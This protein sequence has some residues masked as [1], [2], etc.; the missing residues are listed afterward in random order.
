MQDSEKRFLAAKRRLFDKVFE[1]KLNPEQ[2]RAVFTVKGPVLVLAG[3]GSGKTT[4]LVN[5]IAYII[6]YG[7]AYFSHEVPEGVTED[8][9]LAL[10]EAYSLPAEDIEEILPQFITEPTPPWAVLAITFT[11]KA[12]N[13]IKD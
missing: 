7:N 10:E 3:A 9:V 5:R 1:E 6:R 12:A 13:E 4:V 2:R 11:N 8:T